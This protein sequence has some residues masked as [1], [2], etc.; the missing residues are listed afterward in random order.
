[1]KILFKI[2]TKLLQKSIKEI[3]PV[4]VILAYKNCLWGEITVK[5]SNQY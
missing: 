2:I 1:M 4:S 5:K 3:G